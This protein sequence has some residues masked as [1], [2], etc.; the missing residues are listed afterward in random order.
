MRYW[1]DLV[2]ALPF[3][4]LPKR[5]WEDWDLPVVNVV[6]A[7]SLLTLFAGTTLGITGFFAYIER[8]LRLSEFT[9]PP[10]MI[11][12]VVSYVI[13]TPRG[14]FSLYLVFSGLVRAVAWY[15]GEP[16]GDPILT[17]IDSAWRRWRHAKDRR[18]Q[19]DAR[20]ALE[21]R[22]E[23]DR[24]YDGAWA[25]LPDATYVV[26]AARRKPGWDKGTWVI[27][28]DGWFTL[29]EPFDRPMPNGLRTVYP[30]TLQTSTLD[31]LRKGVSYE[32]PPLR[33]ARTETPRA[34]AES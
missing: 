22:D 1:L 2:I 14:V 20:L 15:I 6:F 27:T 34:P 28:N 4:A 5:T 33:A 16:H 17:G 3:A 30:L 12:V 7:S 29:G 10:L 11:L 8:I 23:P 21:K 32:L 24:L 13:G 18:R 25:G 19:T 31:V 9:A 26:V